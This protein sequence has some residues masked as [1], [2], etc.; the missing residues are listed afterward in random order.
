MIPCRPPRSETRSLASQMCAILG[1]GSRGARVPHLHR[2]TPCQVRTGRRGEIHTDSSCDFGSSVRIRHSRYLTGSSCRSGAVQSPYC[3]RVALPLCRG[4]LNPAVASRTLRSSASH[5]DTLWFPFC[6]PRHIMI[7]RDRGGLVVSM[8]DP[9]NTWAPVTRYA[10]REATSYGLCD[11]FSFSRSAPSLHQPR[12]RA[13]G[14]P[15]NRPPRRRYGTSKQLRPRSARGATA[16]VRR[17]PRARPAN[18]PGG[19]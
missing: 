7:L 8:R 6:A 4:S 14:S 12:S 5:R 11:T 17:S 15:P 1:L 9:R 10:S 16:S 19:I 18:G 13:L 2:G 3:R